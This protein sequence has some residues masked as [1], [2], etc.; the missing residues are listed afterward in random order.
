[1]AKEVSINTPLPSGDLCAVRVANGT[2]IRPTRDDTEPEYPTDAPFIP[3]VPLL[4]L[5]LWA[6][7]RQADFSAKVLYEFMKFC[8]DRTLEGNHHD[9]DRCGFYGSGFERAH[10]YYLVLRSLLENS[11]ERA[12][13][14]TPN[15][16]VATMKQLTDPTLVVTDKFSGVSH[17]LSYFL[18]EYL[19]P[20]AS[21]VL[22]LGGN[23]PGCD[24]LFFCS[25]N[26]AVHLYLYQMKYYGPTTTFG[27]ENRNAT[28]QKVKENWGGYG[29]QG[30]SQKEFQGLVL[31]S[32]ALKIDIL[33]RVSSS[34]PPDSGGVTIRDFNKLKELYGPTLFPLIRPD[35]E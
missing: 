10:S 16:S 20:T 35:S 15:K 31:T 28:L 18:K 27:L 17:T 19:Q 29:F 22:Q 26:G 21:I 4:P 7:D 32:I 34:L 12:Y 13:L 1:M 9:F 3:L 5:F 11:V 33:G 14:L 25:N 2:F 8:F 30:V 24:T 23:F 6:F